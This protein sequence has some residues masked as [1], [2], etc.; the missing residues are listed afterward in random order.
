MLIP[1]TFAL[2]SNTIDNVI[3]NAGPT[4]QTGKRGGGRGGEGAEGASAPLKFS[5]DVPFLAGD[6]FKCTLFER[7]N[8]QCT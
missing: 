2:Y 8:Q 6:S 3:I 4:E 1:F 7:S 5:V